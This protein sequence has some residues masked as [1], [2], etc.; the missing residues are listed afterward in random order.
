[1]DY[2][3]KMRPDTQALVD[4]FNASQNEIEVKLDV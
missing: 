3:E 1:M 2:D 4:A